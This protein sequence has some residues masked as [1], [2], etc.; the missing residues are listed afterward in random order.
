MAD[1]LC[2]FAVVVGQC[3][4]VLVTCGA[5]DPAVREIADRSPDQHVRRDVLHWRGEWERGAVVIPGPAERER[6]LVEHGRR[7]AGHPVPRCAPGF[8]GAVAVRLDRGVLGVVGLCV[9]GVWGRGG[10]EAT[11]PAI[12]TNSS[13]NRAQKCEGVVA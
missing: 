4:R 8:G 5:P 13:G 3:R 10:V 12:K 2:G 11:Q 6:D 1:R 7:V 9:L